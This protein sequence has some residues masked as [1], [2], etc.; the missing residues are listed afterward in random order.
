MK[1]SVSHC[2]F[3][4]TAWLI[5]HSPYLK[6]LTESQISCRT[7]YILQADDEQASRP[8]DPSQC[9]HV[10]VKFS[11]NRRL[12]KHG[13]HSLLLSESFFIILQPGLSSLLSAPH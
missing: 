2:C 9:S 5:V 1:I 13:V 6:Q 3:E 10:C 4:H 11:L 8:R 12:L 7:E